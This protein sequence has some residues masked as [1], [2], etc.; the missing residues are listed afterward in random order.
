MQVLYC[1]LEYLYS[2]KTGLS[3]DSILELFMLSHQYRINS[4]KYK[5]EHYISQHLDEET[6]LPVLQIASVYNAKALKTQCFAVIK[7]H[8]EDIVYHEDFEALSEQ[9]R[10]EVHRNCKPAN[11]KQEKISTCLPA[12]IHK[13]IYGN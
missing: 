13:A 3:P 9:I 1:V 12:T 5:C 2:N 7:N 11:V 10:K 8:Y 4:L 6:V